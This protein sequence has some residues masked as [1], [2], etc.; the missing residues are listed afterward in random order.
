V[1]GSEVIVPESL[2]LKN[3]PE[4]HVYTVIMAHQSVSGND[5]AVHTVVLGQCTTLRGVGSPQNTNTV[6]CSGGK[7]E[8]DITPSHRFTD[9][10]RKR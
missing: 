1:I 8:I 4:T 5:S 9:G 10:I 3:I 6:S 2:S 7:T